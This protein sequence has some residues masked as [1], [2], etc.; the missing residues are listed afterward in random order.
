MS[1]LRLSSS[2]NLLLIWA[3]LR[4]LKSL[5]FSIF[6]SLMNFE[7]SSWNFSVS[8]S[9]STERIFLY[10]ASYTSLAQLASLSD[11]K[12]LLYL[13]AYTIALILSQGSKASSI[14][15][16]LLGFLLQKL[17]KKMQITLFLFLLRK[18]NFI[19]FTRTSPTPTLSLSLSFSFYNSETTFPSKIKAKGSQN[20]NSILLIG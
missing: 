9:F 15:W 20:H 5:D 13:I 18:T 17:L 16:N 7:R 1:I 2:P 3:N 8:F 19:L 6:L 12:L 14:F 10:S 4:S 11:S